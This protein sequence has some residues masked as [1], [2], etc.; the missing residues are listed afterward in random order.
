MDCAKFFFRP[1]D[2][3]RLNRPLPKGRTPGGRTPVGQNRLVRAYA[4][5]L[6]AAS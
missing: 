4:H 1:R 5:F 3:L 2:T 6:L